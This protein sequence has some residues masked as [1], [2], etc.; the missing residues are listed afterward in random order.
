[1]ELTFDA[2]YLY[3]S[4]L[5]LIVGIVL[6]V[7]FSIA[8][9]GKKIGLWGIF[10]KAGEKEWKS[11][12]P[13]YNQITLLKVCKLSPWLV[14]LYLDFLIPVVGYLFGRDVKWVTIIMLVGLVIYRFMIAIRL[15]QAFK[16]GDVF[17]FCMAFF[18][19]IFFPILGCSKDEKYTK[20]DTKKSKKIK[21]CSSI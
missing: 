11:I 17:S 14:L 10:S 19:A 13:L 16:K 5:C 21:S 15:G 3:L 2:K 1:M 18:Q 4:G 7:V 6:S 9:M 20:I 12:V 8:F